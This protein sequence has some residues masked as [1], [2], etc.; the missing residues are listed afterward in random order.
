MRAPIRTKS[1]VA[2]VLLLVFSLAMITYRFTWMYRGTR[3]GG[4]KA[5]KVLRQ[6]GDKKKEMPSGKYLVKEVVDGDTIVLENGTVVRYTGVDTPEKETPHFAEATRAN[7]AMVK[8]KNIDV[9]FCT[10]RQSDKY[11]RRLATLISDGVD[12]SLTL[13]KKGMGRVF[14][15]HACISPEEMDKYWQASVESYRQRLGIWSEQPASPAPPEQASALI[16]KSAVICGKI[17]NLHQG[18]EA[19][20]LNFGPGEKPVFSATVLNRDQK[21]FEE[22]GIVLGESLAGKNLL[23]FGHILDHEGPNMMVTSP[24]QWKLSDDCTKGM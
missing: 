23:L 1:K 24:Y 19:F 13:I 15:D 11:G 10:L 12:V 6:S 5:F 17:D 8:D 20:H 22:S 4:S 16:G 7:A 18:K 9:K 21:R 14:I 2:I 3:F